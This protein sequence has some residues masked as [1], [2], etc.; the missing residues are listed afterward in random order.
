LDF[1]GDH[2]VG[3]KVQERY[4]GIPKKQD[5]YVLQDGRQWISLYPFIAVHYCPHC[6]ARETYFVDAWQG[7]GDEANLRSFERSHEEASEEI[8]KEL[9]LR[10]G[11]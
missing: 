3:P 9:T 4:H 10:L 7:P 11:S 1:S 6:N 2:P 5:L 8:G